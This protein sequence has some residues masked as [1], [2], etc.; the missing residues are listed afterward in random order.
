MTY[1]IRCLFLV[2]GALVSGCGENE[3]NERCIEVA[4]SDPKGVI[5]LDPPVGYDC[6]DD[7]VAFL[8]R[9]EKPNA[10]DVNGGNAG[11]GSSGGDTGG[12]AGSG[13]GAG[14]GAGSGGSG[15]GS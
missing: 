5:F 1:R 13:G 15:G 10:F 2:A 7:L 6:N 3:V 14:G 11:G 8:P 9:I 12:G 4:E